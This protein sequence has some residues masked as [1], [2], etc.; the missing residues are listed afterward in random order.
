MNPIEKSLVEL[1]N[2]MLQ[3]L[4]ILRNGTAHGIYQGTHQAA[5]FE[6]QGGQIGAEGFDHLGPVVRTLTSLQNARSAL[7]GS[8]GQL[9]GIDAPLGVRMRT[10]CQPAITLTE[11]YIDIASQTK[12]AAE[13]LRQTDPTRLQGVILGQGGMGAQVGRTVEA[14]AENQINA[15][16]NQLQQRNIEPRLIPTARA[17]LQQVMPSIR[18]L[19]LDGR[20][21]AGKLMTTV[22]AMRLLIS[23]TAVRAT[24]VGRARI[25]ATFLSIETMLIEFGSR[26]ST[27]II[28]PAKVLREILG[29]REVA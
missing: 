17:A 22:T 21:A 3:L 13:S 26:L 8:L 29:I 25:I 20:E 6:A 14:L 18:N 23:K 15:M 9:Q 4:G 10:L 24:A 28:V 11:E 27:P 16:A 2:A 19:P 7:L 12:M 5:I 1:C